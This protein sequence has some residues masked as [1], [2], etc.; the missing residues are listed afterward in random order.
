MKETDKVVFLHTPK[1]GG[2][3][4]EYFFYDQFKTIRRNYFISF[5]GVDDSRFFNDELV[6][7]RKGG[8]HCLIEGIFKNSQ[9]VEDF[10]NSIHF[11]QSKVLFGHTTYGIGELFPEYNFQYLTVLRDPIERTISNIA[12]FSNI[13]KNSEYVKFGAYTTK[14]DKFSDE[15]WN[16]IYEVLTKEYPTKGL[17]VH[18]NMFLKNC[19]THIL[20]GSKYLNVNEEAN[21]ELA[22]ENSENIKISFFDDFNNGIQRSFD[23]LNIPIDMSKNVKAE[24]GKPKDNPNKIKHGKYYNAPQKVV[25]FVIENNQT[26]IKLYETLRSLL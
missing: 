1:T 3:A 17:L 8:N 15:Y 9:L 19:M 16:F 14:H 4:M 7:K 25:D 21:Y 12:Q 20:A 22:L 5:F 2:G 10:K 23:E 26:D 18:E 11:Q 24:H 13:M 6:T